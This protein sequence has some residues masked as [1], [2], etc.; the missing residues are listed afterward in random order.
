MRLAIVLLTLPELAAADGYGRHAT[1]EL[2]TKAPCLEVIALLDGDGPAFPDNPTPEEQTA[3]W[4][5]V[6][7][8]S[9]R[10]GPAWGFI[11][12]FDAA[13][14]GLQ[15]EDGSTT[16]ERLREECSHRPDL[17]A[18]IHLEGMTFS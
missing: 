11:L 6:G 16:L 4:R 10:I 7:T 13:K 5:E 12:G 17:P 9:G 14:G 3:Y 8:W 2:F 15:G 1:V 18:I